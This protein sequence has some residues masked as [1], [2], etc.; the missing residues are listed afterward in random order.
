[1]LRVVVVLMLA[2]VAVVLA[3]VPAA[4]GTPRFFVPGRAGV[5]QK[6]AVT[7]TTGPFKVATWT[8]PEAD[9]EAEQLGSRFGSRFDSGATTWEQSSSLQYFRTWRGAMRDSVAMRLDLGAMYQTAGVQKTLELAVI[10]AF[11][12]WM[13]TKL[14]QKDANSVQ[15]LLLSGLVPAVTL[16]SLCSIKVGMSSL[17]FIAG[18]LGLVLLQNVV[19]HFASCAVFGFNALKM[20]QKS[21]DL[22]RTAAMEMGTMAPALSV[23]AFVT[24][25]VGPAFTGLA[26]LLDLPCK[27]YMLLF[28]PS[29]LRAK[30]S[31]VAA[32]AP[33]ASGASRMEAVA[34]QLKDP[35]NA[36]IIAGIVLSVIYQGN[37]VARLGFVG[38]ALK[39][40]AAA[41]T[42][43]LFLLIGLKL[44]IEGA[45][46]ALCGVLLLLRQGLVMAAV[47]T[48]LMFSG[49]KSVQM[50]LLVTLTSQA[51]TSVVGFGQIAKAKERGDEGYSTDF[52]F[53]IIGISFPLTIMLNT[54]ACL[55]GSAY[56]ANM[57][58]ISL[59]L[60]AS[61]GLLYAVSR[62]QI[63]DALKENVD[64]LKENVD[65]LEE[66]GVA[67]TK[68]TLEDMELPLRILDE[69]P[70]RIISDAE[71]KVKSY[72]ENSPAVR[73]VAA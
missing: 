72:D 23:F 15:K 24:E 8:H 54:A 61:S 66:N 45:T 17:G 62:N 30:A 53:D 22:R 48:F 42:P 49:I 13:R 55:G 31:K 50:Q 20:T 65:T 60:L 40:L 34:A 58:P 64:T 47:K 32:V 11:G 68:A 59:V 2:V 6:P 1:M 44:S 16:T 4:L 43:I 10:T 21:R 67:F 51:A 39:S 46:P 73:N 7:W 38:N 36:S 35:F 29:V 28:M 52:A 5:L 63:V 41:Q 69:L 37:A 18:G 70:M 71:G 57:Y 14:T 19:A 27:A 56:I 26:A 25:F 3:R 9:L 12:F 33:S